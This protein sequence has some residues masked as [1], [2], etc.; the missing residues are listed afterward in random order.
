MSAK[1]RA[2]QVVKTREKQAALLRRLLSET[3][4]M[5]LFHAAQIKTKL[6][7]FTVCRSFQGWRRC[8]RCPW[9]TPAPPTLPQCSGR[10]CSGPTPTG[11]SPWAT[12]APSWR[13]R[14]RPPAARSV[15]WTAARATWCTWRPC[16]RAA[17]TW[18]TPLRPRFRPVRNSS[19]GEKR[20]FGPL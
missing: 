17:P 15:D 2:R 18:W 14:A 19:R 11:P 20:H 16:R 4:I 7:W 5:R 10:P 3:R 13:A 6:V 8:H 12:T 1:I 9:S